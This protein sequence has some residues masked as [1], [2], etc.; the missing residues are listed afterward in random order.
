MNEE[1]R[2][3]ISAEIGKLRS[4]LQKGQQ[5]VKEFKNES[6]RGLNKV[7]SVAKTASQRGAV[8]LAAMGAAFIAATKS[9]LG[10]VKETEEFRQSQALLETAFI[11]AGADAAVAGEVYEKLYR[12][13]GDSQQATEAAQHLALLSTEEKALSEW[14]TI[15]QGVFAKFSGSIPVE[16]LLE[17]AN[18]TAK[19]GEVQG[20]LADA[21]EWTDWTVDEFNDALYDLNTVEEREAFI[22]KELGAIY[23]DAAKTYENTAQSVLKQHEA[24]LELQKANAKLA[25]TM[26]PVQT[27]LTKIQAELVGKLAPAIQEF[28]DKHGE[29]F[30]DLLL[31][32]GYLLIDLAT[33]AAN[34][35]EIVLSMIG[36]FAAGITTLGVFARVIDVLGNLSLA[37]IIGDSMKATEVWKMLGSLFSKFGLKIAIIIAAI[38]ALIAVVILVIKYWDEIAKA[39]VKAWEWIKVTF[40]PV[41]A[42][43]M[44]IFQPL[45]DW[46]MGLWEEIKAGFG[47]FTSYL[48]GIGE[49]IVEIFSAAWT[50]IEAIINNPFVQ[51]AIELISDIFKTCIADIIAAFELAWTVIKAVWSL[52]GPWFK[53]LGDTLTAIFKVVTA[54]FTGDWKG[55]WEAVKQAAASGRDYFKTLGEAIKSIFGG[56]GTFLGNSFK[57][58]WDRIKA[59]FS[60][61]GSFFTTLWNKVKDI[62]KDVGVAVGNAIKN[63]VSKAV[64]SVLSTAV[65]II[66]GF[67]KA[68]N[69]AIGVIN[70]IPGVKIDKLNMLEVPKMAK[71]GV[72]DSATLAMF[73]E[74]GAEAVI[75]LE[76]N[77]EWMEKLADVINSR[78]GG[79]PT[80]VVLTVD[81]KVFAQT[82]VSTINNLT[83]QQGKLAL[84][85]V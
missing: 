68:I 46:F 26:V 44:E 69:A 15:A 84:N 41:G 4:E 85:L 43:F 31:Q 9:L 24:E 64:N 70:A 33:W 37:E 51:I 22:R 58:A 73:G 78:G 21:L 14:T 11:D 66:N 49:K 35:S 47:E 3:I 67:I 52:V 61:W 57:N 28:V 20:T 18:H 60:A 25:E 34:N 55:A 82:A 39:A 62:F 74:D 50:M 12:V 30:A 23:N 75:P 45:I 65:K 71:G 6:E 10:M 81:G 40:A 76:K 2:I 80:P 5:E 38:V 27:E 83:R 54:I 7:A 42:W 8:A 56:V 53:V 77:T 32:I 1:L 29:Q 48:P 72:V 17:A 16:S 36:A 79:A 19:L 63:T 13:L 59:V